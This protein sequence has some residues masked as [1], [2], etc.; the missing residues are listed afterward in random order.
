MTWNETNGASG[1]IL[2]RVRYNIPKE[3]NEEAQKTDVFYVGADKSVIYGEDSISETAI[4]VTV[5]GGTFVVEDKQNE[6]LT[7]NTGFE[8]SQALISSGLPFEYTVIPVLSS[9][10]VSEVDSFRIQYQNTQSLSKRGST[11]GYGHNVTAT[12]AASPNKIVISWNKPADPENLTPALFRRKLAASSSDSDESTWEQIGLTTLQETSTSY[13]DTLS[14][15]EA[16]IYEYT[17]RYG[18]TT[19][20]FSKAYLN[21][22]AS[23]TSALGEADNKGYAF[24]LYYKADTGS[25]AEFAEKLEWTPFDSSYRKAAKVS[26]YEIYLKNT[27]YAKGWQKIAT[28]D[29]NGIRTAGYD[30][31]DYAFNTTF[32]YTEK[33]ANLLNL[34][35]TT[36]TAKFGEVTGGGSYEGLLKVLRDPRHYYK[37]VM[38]GSY[39]E[40]GSSYNSITFDPSAEEINDDMTVY[41]C[42]QITD[43]ELIR[44]A[45]CVMAYGFYIEEGGLP[46]LSNATSRLKYEDDKNIQTD[47]GG[48]AQ[49]GS[50]SLISALL[51]DSE[52]GKYKADVTMTNYAPSQ[53]TPSGIFSTWLKISMSNVSTRTAG[54]SD[55]YLDK[56]RTENFTVTVGTADTKIPVNYS[57]TLTMSCTGSD[58]LVVKMNNKTII[59]VSNSDTRKFYFPIQINDSHCWLNSTTYGW[60]E[61]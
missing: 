20:S 17:V 43:A 34:K 49:F 15:T 12:K 50:R 54:L 56:F 41:A 30:S 35:P 23:S 36:A 26:G 24:N 39:T 10:D 1:Y 9:D 59:N 48:S 61:D 13:T 52:V 46:D 37:I 32:T 14:V 28:L 27:N 31:G 6:N 58:N 7:T 21:L 47:N 22:L 40:D 3:G 60:W 55:P 18:N 53:L 51:W 19:P 57:T 11:H 8:T 5:N 33:N 44:S 16:N 25:E 29:K 42:R 38:S 2:Q 45:L 4:S